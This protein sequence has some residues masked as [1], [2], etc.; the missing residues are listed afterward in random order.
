MEALGF[1][2]LVLLAL[3]LLILVVVL[4]RSIPDIS[5]YRRVRRM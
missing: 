5:R 3:V 4:V 2:F 1:A